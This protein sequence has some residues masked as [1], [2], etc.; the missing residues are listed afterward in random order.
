MLICSPRS[1]SWFTHEHKH[2]DPSSNAATYLP[3]LRKDQYRDSR[4]IVL[5]YSSRGTFIHCRC[6][7]YCP[8]VGRLLAV[9]LVGHLSCH[10]CLRRS[11]D[12]SSVP[13]LRQSLLPPAVIVYQ[14]R[15]LR[16]A[17]DTT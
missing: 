13:G 3:M 15:P 6:F 11:L 8:R 17:A 10:I 2:N 16:R 12:R 4:E 9:R 1:V 14:R 7:Y 5:G